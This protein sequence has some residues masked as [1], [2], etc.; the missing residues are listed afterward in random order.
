MRRLLIP[1]FALMGISMAQK[2]VQID[3][4]HTSGPPAQDV[5]EGML[6][7]FN[8]KQSDYKINYKFVGDFREGGLKLIAALR[9]GAA[10]D[11]FE[12]EISF[13][14]RLVKDKVAEKLEDNL[15]KE[16]T[17][18]YPGFFETG[19]WNGV[20]YALPLGVS[21]P[22]LFYNA[23]QFGAKKIGVPQTW[24]DITNAAQKLTTRAAKGYI[25]SSDIYTFNVTVM[26]QGGS[27]VDKNGKP[28]FT[29][30]KVVGALE[31]L[32]NLTKRGW[33]QSRNVAEVQFSVADFLR[34]KSFMAVAP[35]TSWPLV[36]DRAEIPFKLGVAPVP[37]GPGGK[38]P[39]AGPMLV[40]IKGASEAK[41]KGLV[42]FWK[43][44]M[45]PAN[46]AKFVKA[47]Y[48]LP[49]RKSAQPLLADFYKADPRRKA[50][51]DQA[52][53]AAIWI[54]D[55]EYTVWYSYLEDAL[56]KAL[57]GGQDA[58]KVLEEAQKR[59]LSVDKN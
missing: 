12:G 51:F 33:A 38:V 37:M 5:L 30:P 6:D 17:D 44:A 23:D 45:Q 52:E 49:L 41:Q 2:P 55:P 32:Q 14:G 31:Y 54:K 36:A 46:I 40:A 13:L 58:K 21:V 16:F 35:I 59:A 25:V 48:Y 39:L 7:E 8:A 47:S 26:A 9:S 28:D 43:Y 15:G 56:E 34:T 19:E 18:F 53:R 20:Q 29:N 11:I 42:A 50:A 57:K 10:P 4:W 22:V 24:D 27:L 3:F 1:L